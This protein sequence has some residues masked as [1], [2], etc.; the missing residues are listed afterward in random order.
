M[1]DS[2]LADID[3]AA[4]LAEPAIGNLVVGTRERRRW[5]R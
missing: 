1:R 2:E 5:S 3:L 4:P